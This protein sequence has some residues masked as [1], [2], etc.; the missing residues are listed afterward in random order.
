LDRSSYKPTREGF[1]VLHDVS[2][3]DNIR[4]IA[5]YLTALLELAREFKTNH[6]GLLILDE[7]RQQNM[8]WG[9]FA[10]ILERLAAAGR[11]GQQ[12]IVATSDQ[13]Q[14]F[15]ELAPELLSNR[16][17]VPFETPLLTKLPRPT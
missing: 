5:A 12:V 6:P 16:V 17:D 1:D 13:H 14:R 7:P 3:S 9:H 15:A 8:K 2:A 10:K 11:H 4:V